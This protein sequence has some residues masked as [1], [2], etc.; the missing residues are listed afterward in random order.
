[1]SFIVTTLSIFF[2]LTILSVLIGVIPLILSERIQHYKQR[3]IQLSIGILL[4]TIFV[5]IIPEG[6][7]VLDENDQKNIGIYIILGFIAV[8]VIEEYIHKLT[9]SSKNNING[10]SFFNSTQSLTS[11]HQLGNLKQTWCLM[12]NNKV[13]FPL[14]IHGLSDGLTL[15]FITITEN[16]KISTVILLATI[17]HKIPAII[18]LVMILTLQQ[19]LN[20]LQTLANLWWFAVSTPIGFLIT[21]IILKISGLKGDAVTG[22]FLVG[23][24]GSLIFALI[25]TFNDEGHSTKHG[26]SGSLD[27]SLAGFDINDL[28]SENI[29]PE[30]EENNSNISRRD[31]SGVKIGMFLL[32]CFIPW[33]ISLFIHEQ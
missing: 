28:E 10:N 27:D 6:L 12:L 25:Q 15:G 20:K 9:T 21:A 30:E 23:S 24:A 13:T 5:I 17:I 33:T 8:Y 18:S 7:A 29:D 26:A 19:N 31:S 4:S 1:M 22:R 16:K 32:G 3:F 2:A 14:F 11:Y